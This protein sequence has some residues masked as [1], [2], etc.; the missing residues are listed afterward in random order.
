M[1]YTPNLNLRYQSEIQFYLE[2][3][4]RFNMNA[5]KNFNVDILI[6]CEERGKKKQMISQLIKFI[7]NGRY[8]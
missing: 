5:L 3:D 6:Q 1:V 8:L 4:I 2:D 7:E